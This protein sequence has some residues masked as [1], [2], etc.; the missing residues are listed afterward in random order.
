MAK[1]LAGK[2]AF[3]AMGRRARSLGTSILIGRAA[4]NSWPQWARSAWSAGWINQ[5]GRH[6]QNEQKSKADHE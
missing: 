3:E 6:A 5:A 1:P 4:R 2:R